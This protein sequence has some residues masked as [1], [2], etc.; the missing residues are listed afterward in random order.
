MFWVA[1]TLTCVEIKEQ[2][3]QVSGTPEREHWW[4]CIRNEHQSWK[5]AMQELLKTQQKTLCSY[6]NGE[7]ADLWNRCS[8]VEK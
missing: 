6:S 1:S 4:N 2:I 3:N 8:D 5:E 7:L